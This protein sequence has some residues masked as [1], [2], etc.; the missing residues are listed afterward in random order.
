MGD[1]WEQALADKL[2]ND[3]MYMSPSCIDIPT[4]FTENGMRLIS[5]KNLKMKA[6]GF[7]AVGFG[8]INKNTKTI[9][10]DIY[11]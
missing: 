9:P 11:I 7:W 4:E 2:I 10:I 6:V 5:S 1:E 8:A 3:S